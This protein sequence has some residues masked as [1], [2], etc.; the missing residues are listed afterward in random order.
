MSFQS[1]DPAFSQAPFAAHGTNHGTGHEPV[2]LLPDQIEESLRG[3]FNRLAGVALIVLAVTG[4]ISLLTW[5]IDDPT[6]AR[7]GAMPTANMLGTTGA[8][9]S[10]I[11]LRGFGLT[12]A[13]AMLPLVLWGVSLL[14]RQR[15]ARWRVKLSLW[16]VGVFSLSGAFAAV[17]LV[18]AW[19]IPHGFG[20][21][22]GDF[23]HA[24][25]VSIM[26]SMAGA[27]G[28]KLATL[29]LLAGGLSALFGSLGAG[30]QELAMLWHGDN[31]RGQGGRGDKRRSP[32]PHTSKCWNGPLAATQSATQSVTGALVAAS[33]SYG[34]T[35]R[36]LALGLWRHRP[37]RGDRTAPRRSAAAVTEPT[38]ATHPVAAH[39]QGQGMPPQGHGMPVRA[40]YSGQAGH[41]G[42]AGYEHMPPQ[43]HAAPAAAGYE[44]FDDGMLGASFDPDS[45]AMAE[46][47]A[48]RGAAAGHHQAGTRQPMPAIG[49][50]DM[51][52]NA[53]LYPVPAGAAPTLMAPAVPHAMQHAISMAMSPAMPPSMSR[54][55]PPVDIAATIPRAPEAAPPASTP[56]EAARAGEPSRG[57]GRGWKGRAA[58]SRQITAYRPPALTM[59]KRPA[60][61]KPGPE[62]SQNVQRGVA[63]LLQDVLTD[64]GVK[65]EIQGVK[66]GPVVTLYELEPARGVKSS[67]I[68]GLSDDIARSMSATSA[69]V[70]GIPGRNVIGIELPNMRREMVY[71]RELLE[72]DIYQSTQAALPVVLGKSIGGEP[73]VADLAR[74]PHVLVAG[75]TGSGKSVGVNAMILSLLYRLGPEQCRFLMIDPKMLE[76][77]VY[78]GIPHLLAPVI[79]EPHK[80][81]AALN[82]VVRE[83]EERYKR[84]AQLAVRNIEVFNGRIRQATEKGEELSR[85]VQTGFDPQTGEPVYET[86]RMQLEA[87][88]YI[89]V[90]VDEMADLMLT[91][92]KEIEDGHAAPGADGARGR[93]PSDHRDAAAERQRHHGHHQGQLPGAHHL[94]GDEQDRQPH[95]PGRAGRRPTAG[96]GRHAVFDRH[97][98]DRARARSVRRRRGG[99][100][101]RSL[102]A[103]A[104]GAGLCRWHRRGR[105]RA[106]R[107]RRHREP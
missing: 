8:A 92:G 31:W 29:A 20:G 76:L 69:R 56:V 55:M 12:S 4:W 5:S 37:G 94:P 65:G 60:P 36:E 18:Q 84:M 24:L 35:L 98:A 66:P 58:A 1:R 26:A 9:L 34:P 30:R 61:V 107:F 46:R 68:V 23:V 44:A 91:A 102:P 80:A 49:Q 71:L 64:F 28:A 73:I 7:A 41:P 90:V 81:V 40:A 16:L 39:P 67:R 83:M 82:W 78:N 72:T 47:F 103:H 19:R 42:H 21:L 95:D 53:M 79:T 105:G 97:G 59:L 106:G 85:T 62:Y 75:T 15:V 32:P 3:A 52:A 17:P 87:M 70:A 96:R 45:R 101:D 57:G 43:Y 38:F 2:R 99:R 10:D 86:E 6:L 14:A 88:P 50:H 33:Q 54:P 63:Q 13:F 77:S 51:P 25:M 11:L 93:H 74:M 27:H 22:F 100:A 48:P 104:R 89:V